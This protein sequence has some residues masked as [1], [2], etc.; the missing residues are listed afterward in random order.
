MMNRALL[1]WVFAAAASVSFACGGN[2]S[3]STGTTSGNGGGSTSSG[4]GTGGAGTGGNPAT[5]SS[6]S[7]GAAST[8]SGGAGGAMC[9]VLDQPCVKCVAAACP[10]TYCTCFNDQ[11]CAAMVL[12]LNGCQVGDSTCTQNCATQNKTGISNAFLV[13]DC[14]ATNCTT[15]GDCPAGSTALGPCEKCLFTKCD[16]QMND[17]IADADCGSFAQ[18]VLTCGVM[19]SC[20]TSC[21]MM[22]PAGATKAQPVQQ[23]QS[24]Q[25]M[26]TCG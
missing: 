16:M 2:D 8:G 18:C 3:G 7:T 17:C 15:N 20:F 26:S 9:Q 6:A 19:P 24:A 5:N 23:C 13:G 1:G 21:G 14:A 25:C 4:T 10:A 12:C 22:Y 11:Y